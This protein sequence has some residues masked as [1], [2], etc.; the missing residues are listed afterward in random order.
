MKETLLIL[1]VFAANFCFAQQILP[2]KDER[3]GLMYK[4]VKIKTRNI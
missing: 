4:A 2:F 3:V 1:F